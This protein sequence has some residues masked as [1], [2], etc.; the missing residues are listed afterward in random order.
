MKKQHPMQSVH[1]DAQGTAR[2]IKNDIVAYLLDKGPFD[3]NHLAMQGFPREDAEQFAQ[4][5]GY[6]V[7]GFA[8]LSYVSK[9]AIQLADTMVDLLP[10]RRVRKKVKTA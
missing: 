6:S 5:I 2:F 1:F 4:L 9:K 10:K 7:D 8:E 3:M